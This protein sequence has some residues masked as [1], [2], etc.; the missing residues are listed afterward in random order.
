[1]N[2]FASPNE[3]AGK[4]II[5]NSLPLWNL[6]RQIFILNLIVFFLPYYVRP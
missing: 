1:M 6:F 4:S 3:V 5:E 2:F